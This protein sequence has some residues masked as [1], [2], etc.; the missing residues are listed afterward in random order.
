MG[1]HLVAPTPQISREWE[2]LRATCDQQPPRMI[3]QQQH[4]VSLWHLEDGDAPVTVELTSGI[5]VDQ[6][7]IRSQA[8][9]R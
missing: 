4:G 3:L 6:K 8:G 1:H 2:P 7:K 5:S 9:D